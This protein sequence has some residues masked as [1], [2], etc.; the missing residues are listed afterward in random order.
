[1]KCAV[2]MLRDIVLNRYNKT[3]IEF[4]P[5]LPLAVVNVAIE[6]EGWFMGYVIKQEKK[7]RGC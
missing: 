4:I 5:L 2:P 1:M 7:V 3:S 6:G